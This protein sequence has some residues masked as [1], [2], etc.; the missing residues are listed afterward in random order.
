MFYFE[1]F[2]VGYYDFF[3][4]IIYNK[5]FLIVYLNKISKMN[6]LK[7]IRRYAEIFEND[8]ADNEKELKKNVCS[9]SLLVIWGSVRIV[10]FATK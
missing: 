1:L 10:Q 9:S 3:T 8:I 4:I 6:V 7:L 5:E 2:W